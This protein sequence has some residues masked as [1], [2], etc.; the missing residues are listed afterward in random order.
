MFYHGF[1]NYMNISFPE[2]EVYPPFLS[3]LAAVAA[4]PPAEPSTDGLSACTASPSLLHPSLE[5]PGI[6]ETSSST[7]F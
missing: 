4:E 7:M 5:M 2:D 1:D 3:R 6:R